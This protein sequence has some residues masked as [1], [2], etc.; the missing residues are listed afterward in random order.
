[1]YI[2]GTTEFKLIDKRSLEDKTVQFVGVRLTDVSR[3]WSGVNI[4]T[5]L[6]Q[7]ALMVNRLAAELLINLG[8][9]TAQEITK[10]SYTS[11]CA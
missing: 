9:D 2:K 7:Y 5:N 10:P 6:L 3:R 4:I 8:L 1:M 11:S